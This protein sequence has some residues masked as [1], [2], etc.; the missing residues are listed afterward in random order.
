MARQVPLRRGWSGWSA[1]LRTDTG[2]TAAWFLSCLVGW[3]LFLPF[4]GPWPALLGLVV[5]FVVHSPGPPLF[6]AW[7]AA[8]TGGATAAWSG[9]RL[10]RPQAL[11]PLLGV[12]LAGSWLVR[13]LPYG[14]FLF[15]E[16]LL[17]VAASLSL[18]VLWSAL[19]VTVD[20]VRLGQEQSGPAGRRR[21]RPS[22]RSLAA[23]A[24]AL[25]T[26]AGIAAWLTRLMGH[27]LRS[28]AAASP[29]AE[30]IADVLRRLDAHFS[31]SAFGPTYER[32]QYWAALVAGA[33]LLAALVSRLLRDLASRTGPVEDPFSGSGSGQRSDAPLAQPTGKVFLSYSRRDTELAR[34]ITRSLEGRLQDIWV[35]WEAIEPSE[36]WRRA[37]REGIR[38]SDALIVL[39]SE[40]SL[41]SAYCR[42]ECEYA[43][44]LGK[45]VLPVLADPSLDGRTTAVM[46][47]H[48][49]DRL[50]AYQRL[51]MIEEGDEAFERGIEGIVSFVTQ[52]YR[53]V[54]FHTRLGNLAHEW[55]DSGCKRGLLLRAEEL[56]L[57]RQWQEHP[58]HAKLRVSLTEQQTHYLGESRRAAR[59][60]TLLVRS[61]LA[62][63]TA[64]VVTAGSLA[65]TAQGDADDQRRKALSRNLAAAS[66]SLAETEPEK[67]VQLALAAYGQ[68]GTTEARGALVSHLARLDHVRTIIAPGKGEVSLLSMSPDGRL[69][70]IE[71]DHAT[72]QIWDMRAA[73]GRGTV[74][75]RLLSWQDGGARSV[76]ADGRTLALRVGQRGE[77]ITLVDTTTLRTKDT[78]SFSQSGAGTSISD[79]GGGLSPDGSH[80]MA[81]ANDES[82]S[83][84]VWHVPGH[85]TVSTLSCESMRMAPSGKTLVCGRGEQVSV[86]G[87]PDLRPRR[88]LHTS[89]W[90]FEGY[91]VDDGVVVDYGQSVSAD[92]HDDRPGQ[93]RVYRPGWSQPWIPG[94]D[95]T[96]DSGMVLRDG[97]HALLRST[98]MKRW[99][100]WDL[101]TRKRVRKAADQKS[102]V[103]GIRA[104]APLEAEY[105]D[106]AGDSESASADGSTVATLTKD[107]S[108]VIWVRDGSGHLTEHRAFPPAERPYNGFAVS[109][110]T[111]TVAMTDSRRPVV[112]LRSSRTG[113]ASGSIRLA[114]LGTNV[115]FNED[116]TLLAV[117]EHAG[118]G[119]QSPVEVFQIPGGRRVAGMHYTPGLKSGLP[120]L[121]F[122]PDN[123][124]LYGVL[125]GESRVT[126][127]DLS[128]GA[129]THDYAADPLG[130]G[131]ADQADLSADGTRLALTGRQQT[132]ILWD[133]ASGERLPFKVRDAKYAALGPDGRTLATVNMDNGALDS[134]GGGSVSLWDI[135]TGKRTGRSFVPE[136]GVFGVW[137]SPDGNTLAVISDSGPVDVKLSLW[138]VAGHRRIGP[139]LLTTQRD[140]AVSFTEDGS[141]L[142]IADASGSTK[143][144]V[145]PEAW[146]SALCGML[147]GPLDDADWRQ[148]APG[149]QYRSP[150]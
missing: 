53:W 85:R 23:Q 12:A 52:E 84:S 32:H 143:L 134:W 56:S 14:S 129:E 22:G 44:E 39:L 80:L 95:L 66:L 142:D 105:S 34:R 8:R 145:T 78:F 112:H 9:R 71:R 120:R 13:A 127:W 133:T 92:G 110:R 149:G 48:D 72:T 46:R 100:L 121:L 27:T 3:A 96:L 40:N 101:R 55:W 11:A 57:A 6:A 24:L 132:V 77:R 16:C 17:L 63:V 10:L 50:L 131:Y 122:S 42:D 25:A 30:G 135:G 74:K 106:T 125:Q 31:G 93:A 49:W 69:L 73:R 67:A 103:H 116:G 99:E 104:T 38:R 138:D 36:Q 98:D 89:A 150:C 2:R 79:Q 118:A 88:T 115:A 119:K 20:G 62:A 124:L 144:H 136:G 146:V 65:V 82:D 130:D 94:R 83:V 113:H 41:R 147:T 87:L 97:R 140:A 5:P 45:R 61:A 148:A 91:T 35:D 126:A 108:V 109:P 19:E 4:V 86:L 90:S 15:W 29:D 137:F 102:A 60:R 70:F 107:G 123:Q 59:R 141:R 43:I 18:L 33:A 47:E 54:A 75:G 139:D 114:A 1:A 128:T 28:R 37:I 81:A 7:K 117:A 26:A 21:A 68:A 76:T 64:T 51:P 111:D 58:V